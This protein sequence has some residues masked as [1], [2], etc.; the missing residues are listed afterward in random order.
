M[1]LAVSALS[2]YALDITV[3]QGWINDWILPDGSSPEFECR[4]D[5]ELLA[6]DSL[7]NED[8]VYSKIW[9]KVLVAKRRPS[10]INGPLGPVVSYPDAVEIEGEIY[11]VL[12]LGNIFDFSDIKELTLPYEMRCVMDNAF[13]GE[14]VDGIW[15]GGQRWI[16]ELTLPPAMAK[17][18]RNAFNSILWLPDLVMQAPFPPVCVLSDDREVTVG[19]E[20]SGASGPFAKFIEGCV[21]SVPEGSSFF[22]RS[23]PCFSTDV[24]YELKEISMADIWIMDKAT[25]YSAPYSGE[26]SVGV[27]YIGNSEAVL[28]SM[29]NEVNPTAGGFLMPPVI[30]AFDF[31]C[32]LVGIGR[33][34]CKGTQLEKVTLPETARFV[35]DE[36]FRASS[37]TELTIPE[38]CRFAGYKAFADC[39]SL[40]TVTILTK[41]TPVF[42]PDAFDGIPEDATLVTYAPVDRSAAPWNAFAR[43]DDRSGVAEIPAEAAG[44]GTLYD[45]SGLPVANPRPGTIY[46]RDGAKVIFR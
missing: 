4:Y 46:V 39:K 35:C 3:A 16:D 20:L 36:A 43:I 29:E 33:G 2:G 25:M 42:A 30:H 28:V 14:Y 6:F 8:G 22:Y 1:V 9:D 12:A 38:N 10:Y 23:H 44:T 26:A 41:E 5:G 34:A 7:D 45:L 24:F 13:T 18:G 37:L 32:A 27:A 19:D 21:L 15:M 40:K 11:M 17:F 31:S